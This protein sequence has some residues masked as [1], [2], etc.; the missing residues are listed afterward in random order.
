MGNSNYDNARPFHSIEKAVWVVL[1]QT[2]PMPLRVEI[3]LIRDALNAVRN[4]GLEAVCCAHAACLIPGQRF[5]IIGLRRW[6]EAKLSHGKTPGE[7][8]RGLRTRGLAGP[9]RRR[10]RPNAVGSQPWWLRRG[11]LDRLHQALQSAPQ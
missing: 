8:E 4:G 3:R 7:V 1:Q 10:T 2:P 6:E 9:A 5:L 11:V